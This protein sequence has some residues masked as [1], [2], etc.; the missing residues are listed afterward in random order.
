M[1]GFEFMGYSMN[2]LIEIITEHEERK[3]YSGSQW[4]SGEL[5]MDQEEINARK[6]R[7]EFRS[8]LADLGRS[9]ETV[10]SSKVLEAYDLVHCPDLR[11]PILKALQ[12]LMTETEVR[13]GRDAGTEH[14]GWITQYGA[15]CII[16]GLRN[17]GYEIVKINQK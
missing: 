17:Q 14:S 2:K 5:K 13:M 3:F 4:K 10:F 9:E 1:S 8:K 12:S 16:D 7:E 6:K 11:N 15:G